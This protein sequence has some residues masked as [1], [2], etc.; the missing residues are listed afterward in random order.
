MI[1]KPTKNI[2]KRS[3]IKNGAN[4]SLYAKINGSINKQGIPVIGTK[5]K[6]P[7]DV[8]ETTLPILATRA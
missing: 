4:V 2:P 6:V 8:A 3:R 1:Q 5:I 7:Q